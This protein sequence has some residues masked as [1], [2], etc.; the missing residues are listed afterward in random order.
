MSD[1]TE[2]P[3]TLFSQ[4]PMACY[5]QASDDEDLWVDVGEHQVVVCDALGGVA[6]HAGRLTP[7]TEQYELL[8]CIANAIAPQHH[9]HR[10]DESLKNAS[11]TEKVPTM[12]SEEKD[13]LDTF[14]HNCSGRGR[15]AS[16]ADFQKGTASVP[17]RCG[18]PQMPST[19]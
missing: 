15:N 4:S 6:E 10:R 16:A 5:S 8:A 2:S 12:T 19:R 11:Q 7:I 13:L 18:R 9:L 14:L 1:Q 3:T 17:L